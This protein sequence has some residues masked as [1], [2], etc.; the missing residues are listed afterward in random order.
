M[1]CVDSTFDELDIISKTNIVPNPIH[2][3]TIKFGWTKYN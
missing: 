3:P 1:R 2:L